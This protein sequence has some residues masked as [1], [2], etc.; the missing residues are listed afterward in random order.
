MS[1][2][3]YIHYLYT[4]KKTIT[5]P[6]LPTLDIGKR[7]HL[8]NL[9]SSGDQT[10]HGLI[11]DYRFDTL[12]SKIIPPQ[13]SAND[14]TGV[15]I[16]D[17]NCDLEAL[18]AGIRSEEDL[19]P[20]ALSTFRLQNNRFELNQVTLIGPEIVTNEG[21]AEL[22]LSPYFGLTFTSDG[23]AAQLGLL[24][25]VQAQRFLTLENGDRVV[26]LNSGNEDE[27]VLYLENP[28]QT[29]AMAWTSFAQNLGESQSYAICNRVSQAIPAEVDGVAVAQLTVLERYSSYFMQKSLPA[30]G[31]TIWTPIYPPI[32]WGWSIRTGLRDDGAWD[33]TRRKLMLPIIGHDDL[34]IPM[35]N[36]N[37]LACSNGLNIGD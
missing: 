24:H 21:N 3:E 11:G 8:Q 29:Q 12:S 35:W 2:P 34:Q 30:D 33:I 10:I 27:P 20:Q 9:P 14:E 37:S 13:T 1:E 22:N 31:D 26:L 7:Y 4:P 16:W 18:I 5:K 32:S 17:T 15:Y 23:F 25:L 28:T 6:H 36:N 19:S